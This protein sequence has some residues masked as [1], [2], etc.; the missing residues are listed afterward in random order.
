MAYILTM[1]H[2]LSNVTFLARV[3]R[4]LYK[5]TIEGLERAG[6]K[7]DWAIDN[8]GIARFYCTCGGGYYID[9]GCSKLIIDGKV[10]VKQS[11]GGISRFTP[12]ALVLKDGTEL[13]ADV[14]VL[15]TAYD[16]MKTTVQKIMG[17]KVASRCKDVWDLGDEG[18]LNAMWRPSGHPN[19]WYMGGNL[20]ICRIYSKYLALQIKAVEEGL[21][22]MRLQPR[23]CHCSF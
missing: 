7:L 17:I 10:K 4:S 23:L 18:E 9:V 19:F 16:N 8:S 3:Y 5:E 13:T 12:D 14:V 21:S 20:A 22:R 2:Q 6:F 15:A 11:P 1:G